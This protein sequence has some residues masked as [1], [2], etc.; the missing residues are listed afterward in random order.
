MR[1]FLLVV[2]LV[3]LIV[4][5]GLSAPTASIRKLMNS[6]VSVF[7]FGL[8]RIEE[9]LLKIGEKD[10]IS[11][12]YVVTY[13]WDEN[14]IRIQEVIFAGLDKTRENCRGRIDKLRRSANVDPSTGDYIYE[15]QS[16]SVWAGFFLPIGYTEKELDNIASQLDK[17]IVIYVQ[18]GMGKTPMLC[19]GDLVSKLYWFRD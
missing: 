2:V 6:N 5:S 18:I 13:E 19:S 12:S 15:G 11:N 9:H 17:I 7:S 8:Y 16:R 3:P 14:K 1:A 4:T 10:E